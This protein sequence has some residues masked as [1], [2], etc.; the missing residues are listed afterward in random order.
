MAVRGALSKTPEDPAVANSYSAAE[1][2]SRG[3][4]WPSFALARINGCF[5]DRLYLLK[6]SGGDQPDSLD[7][8][9]FIITTLLRSRSFPSTSV[10]TVCN[11]HGPG[12]ASARVG[13]AFGVPHR[14]LAVSMIT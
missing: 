3:A 8:G 11:R 6:R 13:S 5:E 9:S 10:R 1:P 14:D 12:R 2:R 4:L 7:F